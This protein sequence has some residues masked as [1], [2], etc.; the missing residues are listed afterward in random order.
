MKRLI[1]LLMGAVLL[2]GLAG[3]ETFR[4]L[5]HGFESDMGI[6]Q[7]SWKLNRLQ[8]TTVPGRFANA[9]LSVGDS[10]IKGGKADMAVMSKLPEA[11]T[12]LSVWVW[13][14]EEQSRRPKIFAWEVSDQE[15]EKLTVK[16]A[17]DWSGWKKLELDLSSAV[18]V[19]TYRQSKGNKK[20]DLPL[21][22]LHLSWFAS[23]PGRQELAFDQLVGT[24]LRN[25]ASAENAAHYPVDNACV[26][27]RLVVG[28]ALR[29][30]AVLNNPTDAA[31]A[32]EVDYI[33]FPSHDTETPV[34]PDPVLGL[35]LA[36]GCPSETIQ[37]GKVVFSNT[38]T[39]GS[40]GTSAFVRATR[41]KQ[42]VFEVTQ[43]LDLGKLVSPIAIGI[44]NSDANWVY[45]LN[46]DGSVDGRNY[47]PLAGLQGVSLFH[48]WQPL[49]LRL[50]D[51]SPL[52][53]LQFSY[54]TKGVENGP[55]GPGKVTKG[56]GAA[57]FSLPCMVKVYDGLN[58]ESTELPGVATELAHGRLRCVARPGEFASAK[59]VI[60]GGKIPGPGCY[61]LG[62]K[63][64]KSGAPSHMV[65][66][67]VFFWQP[68]RLG[69]D[70]I[71]TRFG[72]NASRMEN[73]ENLRTLG[74]SLVRF[75]NSKW[76]MFSKERG[77]LDF[78]GVPPW[79]V[80][81]DAFMEKYTD[82][83]LKPVPLMLGAPKWAS[84]HPEGK[85]A[86]FYPPKEPADYREFA[87][88]M[89]ARYG[90]KKIPDS[91][92]RSADKKSGLNRLKYFE[93]WNEPDLNHPK[94]GAL[95]GTFQDYYPI[96]RAGYEGVKKADPAAKVLNGGLAG[97]K[98]EIWEE[99][100]NHKYA[101]GKSAL[102]FLDVM[103]IHYYCG[104]RAPEQAGTNTNVN[105]SNEKSSEPDFADK[106]KRLAR[107]RDTYKPG[108]PIWLTEMGWD[109]IGGRFV[110]EKQQA[111]YL[112]RASVIAVSAGIDKYFVYRE[113][114]SGRTLYASCGLIREDKSWK[115][116]AFSYAY[117][118]RRLK[119]AEALGEISNAD[120]FVKVYLF[121][122]KAG[123]SFLVAWNADD[124]GGVKSKKART[125]K[126]AALP[127][128]VCDSFGFEMKT[129]T[130]IELGMFP[131]YID[132]PENQTS[133]FVRQSL[134]L[135][136]EEARAH[137]QNAERRLIMLDFGDDQHVAQVFLG[138]LRK[139]SPVPFDQTWGSG[140]HGFVKGVT[141]NEYK[142]W[143]RSDALRCDAVRAGKDTVFKVKLPKGR[144]EMAFGFA[145]FAGSSCQLK[146]MLEQ[147]PVLA[148]EVSSQDNG[149]VSDIRKVIEVPADNTVLTVETSQ[150]YS[151]WYFLTFTEQLLSGPGG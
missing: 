9:M 148:E 41:G 111:A 110:S 23:T 36:A 107:W 147:R 31:Q 139:A 136:A 72:V 50:K 34:A 66:R 82:L 127:G 117:M 90:S 113:T 104:T 35:D 38:L 112:V 57:H 140:A 55:I 87:F 137:R 84:S 20:L 86:Y 94:W 83:G 44:Q 101:D 15:G 150:G 56:S 114:D 10:Q 99:M 115:P 46:V 43:R 125:L 78:H 129:S 121:Q 40:R 106:V 146:V 54:S 2:S 61:V 52:R 132:L 79:R 124:Q 76:F 123:R 116:S 27:D 68:N 134:A 1:P 62:L 122:N 51:V 47:T 89:A 14:P 80:D 28:E 88:Q 141:R 98:F 49:V 53:Y 5:L 105:R 118:L 142:H 67:K 16:L 120:P 145:P 70:G 93:I 48:Q 149:W 60:P 100:R 119:Q 130:Q 131:V 69:P 133:S 81:L 63:I 143:R 4:I 126:L 91:A 108:T 12:A 13:A 102:D 45:T 8:T 96:L 144:F 77:K 30:V 42:K 71:E 74:F 128:A 18:W 73:A 11:M 32:L 17:V 39:D 22:S 7:G 75:E 103:N 6:W 24:V 92:L 109:T 138:G 26:P 97:F 135:K 3:A 37:A 25:D 59:L 85:R 95:I 65:Y 151:L 58:D 64:Q 29:A 21:K 33:L 19:Q